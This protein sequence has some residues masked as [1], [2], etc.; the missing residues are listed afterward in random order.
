[1]SAMGYNPNKFSLDVLM[2][3]SCLDKSIS[4]NPSYQKITNLYV[5]KKSIIV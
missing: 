3:F 1:M 5:A 4:I 2:S